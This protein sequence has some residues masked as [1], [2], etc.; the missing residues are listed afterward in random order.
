MTARINR[1]AL[2][3]TLAVVSIIAAI[4]AP[5]TA[6]WIDHPTPGIPRTAD[7]KPNLT[8]PVPRTADGKPDLS[9]L[10]I[11]G[12]LGHAMNI[13]GVEM[14][15]WAQQV[16]KQRQA[17]YGHEDPVV[18]CLP[19]GPR[20]GLH[21]LEPLRILQAPT[22][23]VVLF[24]TSPMRQIFTDGRALP[25]DPN[26][27]WMGYSIGRWEGDT[28]VVETTGYNDKTWLDF[29]GHP[30]SEALHVTER[31][32]R[33]DFGHMELAITYEDSKTYVKPWTITTTVNFVPD[34]ELLEAVCQENE[35][36]RHRLVG[37]VSDERQSAKKVGRDVLARYAG[38]YEVEML[39]MWTIAVDG[40][41]LTIQMANGGEKLSTFAQSE[42]VFMFPTFG[43][44]LR[45]VS[46]G[47]GPAS[48][49]VLTIVEGDL[50][51]TRR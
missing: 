10:W 29:S 31:Y 48:G 32:R 42:T 8:A 36:D 28:F 43:G 5:A 14:L 9:G 38:T 19:E 1:V 18:S 50:Q 46:D 24:E 40:D 4:P 17:T 13:T 15:P 20:A 2:V 45:F 25:K 41:E 12:G 27:S 34:T 7:G 23:T 16:Y 37:R 44:S 33:T 21:G 26:P 35:K 3:A 49:F 51:A 39:G 30:H 22:M 47:K 6:Q 11:I